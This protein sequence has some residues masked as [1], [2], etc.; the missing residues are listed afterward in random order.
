[1]IPKSNKEGKKMDQMRRGRYDL[2]PQ[3]CGTEKLPQTPINTQVVKEKNESSIKEERSKAVKVKEKG[4][5]LC[6]GSISG[7]PGAPAPQ[8]TPGV[9]CATC[10]PAHI[11]ISRSLRMPPSLVGYLS[12]YE[13]TRRFGSINYYS[14]INLKAFQ[15]LD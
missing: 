12:C 11:E 6:R 9:L 4:G 10:T 14:K 13:P 2:R 7:Y 3:N 5:A 8:H 15:T 1:M